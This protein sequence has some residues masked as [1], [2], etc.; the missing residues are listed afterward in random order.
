MD[1]NDHL[2]QQLAQDPEFRREWELYEE[3]FQE[4]RR[5]TRW[6][7]RAQQQRDSARDL[8][9]RL[10]KRM[11]KLEERIEALE[12][13][14]TYVCPHCNQ[15][16]KATGRLGGGC[17]S[18]GKRSYDPVYWDNSRELAGKLIREMA[19]GKEEQG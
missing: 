18:C 8:A 13:K 14:G 11:K 5:L 12:N 7:I 4:Q 1:F 10:E 9:K 15:R 3:C 16:V 6:L 17:P 2:Q 19:W